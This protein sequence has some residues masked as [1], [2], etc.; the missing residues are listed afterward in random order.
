M[1]YEN[2][3]I[4]T[5]VNT[6]SET[7]RNES[8]LDLVE[9]KQLGQMQE[10]VFRTIFSY[11]NSTDQEISE[12]SNIPLNVVNA[13]RNELFNEGLICSRGS[14]TNLE[15]GKANTTWKVNIDSKVPKEIKGFLTNA[16]MNKLEK[17]IIQL[18]SN[19]NDFQKNK[20][21]CMLE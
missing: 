5:A 17:M 13:R 4:Q 21:R 3:L 16:E 19:G 7:N 11:P 14:K 2:E 15:T 6:L 18:N 12:L 1:N 8:Y 10:A 9:S 20:I